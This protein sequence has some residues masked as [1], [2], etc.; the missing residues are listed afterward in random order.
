MSF[1][2]EQQDPSKGR[3]GQSRR[4]VEDHARAEA[5]MALSR[6]RGRFYGCLTRRADALFELT[7]AVLCADGPVT[8]L[9]AL[10]LCAAF[11]RGHGAL[12]DALAAGQI[13]VEPLREALIAAL[14]PAAPLLFAVDVTPYPRPDAEC[15]A[16][17]AHCYAACRCD[18]T[19]KTIPGWNYSWVVGLEW[20]SASWT[21]P[22]DACR[23]TPDD[24]L[25][26]VTADQVGALV[27][28][29]RAAGRCGRPGQP[30]PMAV[31]DCGYPAPALADALAGVEV[32]LLVRLGDEGRRVFYADPAPR[33]PGQIGRPAR[34]GARFKL[35]DPTT[36]W[37][38]DQV[39]VVG[40]SGRYGRVEVRAWSGLHQR[41]ET[42]GHFSG[43]PRPEVITGTVIQVLVERLPDGRAPHKTLWLW[44]SGPAGMLPDLDV[45]W[46]AYLRRFDAEH[47]FRF[48]KGTLG[49]TAARV[50][51]PA[52]ADRWTWLL[53]AAYTQLRLARGLARDLRRPWEAPPDPA[54][55][56]SPHRVRRGFRHIRDQ[57]GVPARA[58]KPS[59]P[60]PGRPKGSRRGPARRH[61]DPAG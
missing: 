31:L 4:R 18:G 53:L 32:Q 24:E 48:A 44:W 51:S 15:S 43:R 1:D 6:F 50:R 17:R 58:P 10:S 54:R 33:R 56:L 3:D 9:V 22:V 11:R 21:A 27:G 20:G 13:A 52:Q 59:R 39:H 61:P 42:R 8:S 57:V 28:R 12:Y 19:R 2:Q 60:G 23:L 7:E 30:V 14:P 16:G 36:W 38:P 40:D 34:H 47:A 35:A 55:P 26:V 45:V 5:M 41:L 37:A 29:L 46:R 49:W 25:V